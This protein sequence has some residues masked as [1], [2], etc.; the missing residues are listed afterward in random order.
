MGEPADNIRNDVE[1]ARA[2]LGQ[3]LNELE[4]QVKRQ[5][6]WRVQFDRHPRV[7]LGSAF[8]AGLM[9]AWVTSPSSARS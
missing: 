8:A 3:D 4:Y 2:R 1:R 5:F 7:F 6:D 9:L